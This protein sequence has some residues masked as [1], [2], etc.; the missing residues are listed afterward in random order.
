MDSAT[1]IQQREAQQQNQ[2]D[3]ETPEVS[4]VGGDGSS[5]SSSSVPLPSIS[6]KHLLIIGAIVAIAVVWHLS[7][8][9]EPGSGKPTESLKEAKEQVEQEATVE[10]NPDNIDQPRIEV[11]KDPADPLAADAAVLNALRKAGKLEDPDQ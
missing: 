1:E 10:A 9:N 5:S 7:K 6:K 11:P 2:P 4:D 8:N 3:T